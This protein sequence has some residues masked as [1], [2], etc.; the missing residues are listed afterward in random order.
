LHETVRFSNRAQSE[1]FDPEEDQWR[2]S[3]VDLGKIHLCGADSSTLPETAE[4]L[5]TNLHDV[6]ERPVTRQS[7]A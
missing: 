1:Q 4:A 2:E 6:I 5:F 7:A 3:V